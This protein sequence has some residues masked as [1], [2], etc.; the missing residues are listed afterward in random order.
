MPNFHFNLQYVI[1]QR[2]NNKNEMSV[3]EMTKQGSNKGYFAFFGSDNFTKY[4]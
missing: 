4:L 3:E 1:N 2:K